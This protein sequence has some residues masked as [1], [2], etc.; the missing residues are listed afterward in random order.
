[1]KRT[2]RRILAFCALG[3]LAAACG[4]SGSEAE[5]G[6][7]SSAAAEV[8]Q[9]GSTATTTHSSTSA[10]SEPPSSDSE[11]TAAL[12]VFG[13]AIAK[14]E[15]E[16]LV[17]DGSSGIVWHMP[18]AGIDTETS[19]D[20]DRPVNH[21][22]V[23]PDGTV[24]SRIDLGPTF[25]AFA[26]GNATLEDIYDRIRVEVWDQGETQIV[27]TRGYS[28]LAE[29][30]GAEGLGPYAPGIFSLNANAASDPAEFRRL[31]GAGESTGVE[32]MSERLVTMFGNA[33][34]S[35]DGS[36]LRATTNGASALTFIGGDVD[37]IALGAAASLA[38]LYG[39]PVED[40]AAM[41]VDAYEAS[42][43]HVTLTHTEENGGTLIYES[44][45][46]LSLLADLFLSP[47]SPL[48]PNGPDPLLEAQFEDMEMVVSA[49]VVIQAGH[50]SD[51]P[52]APIATE[53]RTVEMIVYLGLS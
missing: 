13:E 11:V 5:T 21:L 44:S 20:P 49:R 19:V 39:F 30:V 23:L 22:V 8:L 35:S 17:V 16:P 51:M 1:M 40:V 31:L 6:D 25:S 24:Y 27:D 3:A 26:G 32:R 52:L 37:S 38:Q 47:E 42:E 14:L 12:S 10:V 7:A 34:V 28:E 50:E 36:T 48:L 33:E 43:A 4:S 41:Y 29:L 53:D 18:G 45:V 46:D 9:S 15:G 2:S